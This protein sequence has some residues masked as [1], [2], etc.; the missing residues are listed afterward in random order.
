MLSVPQRVWEAEEVQQALTERDFGALCLLIR[1]L[2]SL[3]QEDMARLTGLSQPFLSMLEAGVRKLTNID[4]IVRLLDGLE[5]PME[6][7]GPMLRA[8]EESTSPCG[9][10]DRSSSGSGTR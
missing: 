6:L 10:S 8:S 3:R 9:G 4:K 1:R 7:T 5:A 2:G